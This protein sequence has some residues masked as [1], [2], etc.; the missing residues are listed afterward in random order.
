MS[1]L[2]EFKHAFTPSFFHLVIYH[3]FQRIR[4]TSLE[5]GL[6]LGAEAKALKAEDKPELAGVC[7]DALMLLQ[8][9]SAGHFTDNDR[10]MVR[11]RKGR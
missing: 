11:E 8:D 3:S 10:T 1:L 4:S 2:Q 6:C 9:G 7:P 5:Q